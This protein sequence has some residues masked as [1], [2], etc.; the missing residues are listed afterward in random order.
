MAGKIF[1]RWVPVISKNSKFLIVWPE[2]SV[3]RR[4]LPTCFKKKFQNCTCIIDCTE[5]M[6]QRP[7]NLN[8]RAQ[9]WSNYKHSNTIKYLIAISPA[10]AV[11]FVSPGW[12]GRTSDKEI[13]A[14]SGFLDMVKPGDCIMADRG[15]TIQDELATRGAVLKIPKFTKG[16]SQMNAKEVDFSRKISN[17]RI[18]VERVIGRLRIFHYLQSNIPVQQ[19]DLLDDAM[20]IISSL[21]NLNNSVVK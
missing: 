8:A 14:E 18:H 5:I 6:M 2:R 13:T 10:G 16:K 20:I 1:R 9:T 12:G 21:I 7:F 19:A 17:V 11:T 15:F 3:L 4:N